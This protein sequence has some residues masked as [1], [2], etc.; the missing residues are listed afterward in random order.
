MWQFFC[1]VLDE[2]KAK[3]GEVAPEQYIAWNHN[4]NLQIVENSEA[5]DANLRTEEGKRVES[6]K[7]KKKRDT[8]HKTMEQ[9]HTETQKELKKIERRHALTQEVINEIQ[10]MLMSKTLT[11]GEQDKIHQSK[12][13]QHEGVASAVAVTA[14]S[15]K[16]TTEKLEEVKEF[17]ARGLI[18]E[19]EFKEEKKAILAENRK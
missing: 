14:P 7:D 12:A 2:T 1:W 18:D 8:V 13:K 16:T 17:F 19:V 15:T 3:N 4:A 5:L 10:A 11:I 9:R 6:K